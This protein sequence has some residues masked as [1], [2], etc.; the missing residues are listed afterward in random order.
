MIK[1]EES[2]ERSVQAGVWHFYIEQKEK[3]TFL[4]FHS[5]FLQYINQITKDHRLISLRVPF[6]EFQCARFH[7]PSHEIVRMSFLTFLH[8][9]YRYF[10]SSVSSHS[11]PEP[12][13]FAS[14]SITLNSDCAVD[15]VTKSLITCSRNITD[16]CQ[17]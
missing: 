3:H 13:W 15:V 5:F 7:G 16:Q 12:G 8:P 9:N 14:K 6:F 2:R 10:Q 11:Y 4:Y 1:L 17:C